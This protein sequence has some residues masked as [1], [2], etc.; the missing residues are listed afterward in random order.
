MVDHWL[1]MHDI[2]GLISIS[3]EDGVLKKEAALRLDKRHQADSK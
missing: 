1:I 2:L 3:T